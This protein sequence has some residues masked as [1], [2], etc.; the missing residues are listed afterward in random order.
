M[1]LLPAP[2]SRQGRIEPEDYAWV[3]GLI[4]SATIE[5]LERVGR[6]LGPLT[7]LPWGVPT[8]LMLLTAFS[9]ILHRYNP[10]KR[11]F[12]LGVSF[13]WYVL[14]GDG[15]VE[16]E[17]EEEV[18]G[19]AGQQKKRGHMASDSEFSASE[20]EFSRQ[21]DRLSG[22]HGATS[23]APTAGN[24]LTLASLTARAGGGGGGGVGSR[25]RGKGGGGGIWKLWRLQQQMQQQ[26]AQAP[27]NGQDI[28]A[29]WRAAG[30][31][32]GLF[33][34]TIS[35]AMSSITGMDDD[36]EDEEDE[37]ND[38]L[39]VVQI[40][41]DNLPERSGQLGG[42]TNRISLEEERAEGGQPGREAISS[43]LPGGLSPLVGRDGISG[44]GNFPAGSGGVSPLSRLGSSGQADLAGGQNSKVEPT[45]LE[46]LAHVGSRLF[47]AVGDNDET[48]SVTG[49]GSVKSAATGRMTPSGR[50]LPETGGSRGGRPGKGDRE[51][52]AI[53]DTDNESVGR[54]SISSAMAHNRSRA[55]AR[56]M[57]TTGGFPAFFK[58]FAYG[59]DRAT[60]E[61][62]GEDIP[63]CGLVGLFVPGS[64]KKAVLVRWRFDQ[65]RYDRSAVV[66]FAANF[67]FLA[68]RI[69]SLASIESLPLHYLPVSG[70]LL[71]F[72]DATLRCLVL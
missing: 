36:D 26:M 63:P 23:K 29:A 34:D 45:L 59:I 12:P 1:D 32:T 52:G 66:R 42:Q 28:R 40:D 61:E 51:S 3:P 55:A 37:E 31:G 33:H 69:A 41:L 58:Y 67:T 20:D 72:S 65:S 30:S 11:D 13:G 60:I 6:M 7:G 38:Q 53:S 62:E 5:G 48:G 43:P 16:E 50:V 71:P 56:A 15:E 54:G 8:P 35:D 44:P 25:G 57:I 49:G 9:T 46:M 70:N 18:K 68:E 39:L 2:V 14:Q 24:T 4:D 47:E 21:P 10:S 17:D 27:G 64:K 22:A 19:Q